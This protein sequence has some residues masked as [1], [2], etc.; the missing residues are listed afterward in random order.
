M[1]LRQNS[2][3]PG[4]LV[5]QLLADASVLVWIYVWYR[6]GRWVHDSLVSVG[7]IGY[8]I[9]SNAGRVAGSLNQAGE[10]ASRLPLVGGQ[11]G[12]P[13]SDAGRQVAAIASSGRSAGDQ[14]TS[15]ATPAGWLVALVPILLVIAVWLPLRLRYARRAGAVRELATEPAG[16]E[17]LALRALANQPLHAL[18][19]VSSDP[20]AAWREGQLEATYALADL[21]LAATGVPWPRSASGRPAVGAPPQP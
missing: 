12:G 13:I 6:V 8:S 2:A 18:M 7:T 14:L 1:S 15:A 3:R 11:V 20:V 21:E 19:K 17:L 10:S 4:R 9:D 5:L 16:V